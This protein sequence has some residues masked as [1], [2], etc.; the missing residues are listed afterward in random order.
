MTRAIRLLP[1]KKQGGQPPRFGLFSQLFAM[2]VRPA[3]LPLI[4][5]SIIIIGPR[6][7]HEDLA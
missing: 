2:N 5:G 1:V 6:P 4:I 3:K 7:G